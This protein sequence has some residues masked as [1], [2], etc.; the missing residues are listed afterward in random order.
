MHVKRQSMRPSTSGH[1]E[2]KFGSRALPLNVTPAN[3]RLLPESE[4]NHRT[5]GAASEK[6]VIRVIRIQYEGAVS[7]KTSQ[8]FGFCPGRPLYAAEEFQM[9][10]PDVRDET[11]GRPGN[12]RQP[13]GLPFGIHA[14][15]QYRRPVDRGQPEHRLRQADSIVQIARGFFEAPALRQR[16]RN[17]LLRGGFAVASRHRHNGNVEAGSMKRRQVL[18]RFQGIRNLDDERN[19]PR[20]DGLG[21]LGPA[22]ERFDHDPIGSTG[23]DLINKAVPV[24]PRTFQRDEQIAFAYLPGIGAHPLNQTT[25]RTLQ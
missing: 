18:V 19:R 15:F 25:R 3:V 11:D 8:Q 5:A 20:R 2:T 17:H 24:K 21:G 10:V 16:F 23:E 1:V 12:F 14:Q 7:R 9:V 4:R 6:L 13:G 22:R